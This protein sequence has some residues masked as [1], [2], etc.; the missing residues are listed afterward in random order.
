MGLFDA[1]AGGST[2]AGTL[3]CWTGD[4]FERAPWQDVVRDAERMTGGL[5][6]AGVGRDA[7]VA[8]LLTNTPQTVR[9][10]LGTWLAGGMVASLPVPVRGTDATEYERLLLSACDRLEPALVACDAE[11]VDALPEA[12]RECF[13][14][15]TWESF[16]GSGRAEPS[17]PG[18]DQVAFVQYSSGSTSAPKGCM[19]TPRAIEAQIELL[20]DLLEPLPE[21]DTAMSWLPLS[22]DMGMFGGLLTPWYYGA[23]LVLST[24]R[25]EQSR[26]RNSNHSKT[27]AR[28][29]RHSV[30]A[31]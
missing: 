5:R 26:H 10:L 2:T 9:G 21:G 11:T 6:R 30:M 29:L 31:T 7:C 13:P 8:A 19:L 14:V 24:P 22:H 17:P 18:D 1:L 4:G 3:S 16:A 12:A 25:R 23:S 27:C 20:L 15:R 28:D